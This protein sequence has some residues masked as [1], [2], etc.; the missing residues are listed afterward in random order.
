MILKRRNEYYQELGITGLLFFLL[1]YF[2]KEE[3]LLYVGIGLV[4]LGFFIYPLRKGN[5]IFWDFV[6][7]TLGQVMQSIFL[8][9][10]YFLIVTPIGFIYRLKNKNHRDISGGNWKEVNRKFDFED[11]QKPW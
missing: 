10:I 6:K 5:G 11:L 9:I 8:F 4:V 3:V 7:D 1:W 2:L